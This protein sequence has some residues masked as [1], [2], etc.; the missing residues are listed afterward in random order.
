M[1]KQR[2]TTWLSFHEHKALADEAKRL[3][4]SKNFV[5]RTAIRAY[6]RLDKHPQP[7]TQVT[8]NHEE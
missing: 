1:P 5:A 3:G 8:R 4:T 6:L 2:F 7:V